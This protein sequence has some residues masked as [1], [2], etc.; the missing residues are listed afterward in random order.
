MFQS[1]NILPASVAENIAL[2]PTASIDRARLD[3]ALA[4]SGLSEKVESLPRKADTPLNK[5]VHPDGVDLSG[6]ETQKLLFARAVYKD[7]PVL[8]LDEPTSALDPLAESRMY[9]NYNNAARDKT[10]V[11][12]SHRLASTRFCDRIAYL[13]DGTIAELGT[14]EELM[15]A[16]GAYAQ[17]YG[18]QSSYYS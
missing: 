15:A 13:A 7:A 16:G 9:E 8:V 2:C 14:H 17:L 1:S 6:G 10:S 3:A 5:T 18:I 12:I 11:F 4:L